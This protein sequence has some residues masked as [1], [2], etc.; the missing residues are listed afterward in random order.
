MPL[1]ARSLSARVL[2]RLISAEAEEPDPWLRDVLKIAR[3]TLASAARGEAV[4]CS[5]H[6]LASYAVLGLH[7]EKVWPAIQARR[8]ALGPLSE[9]P[10]K[11]PAQSVKLWFEKTNDARAVNS[12]AANSNDLRDQTISVPMAAPSINALYPNP[13]APSSGKRGEY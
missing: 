10:P 12:C 1:P 2:A 5:P 3:L 9:A 4:L 11:K 13:D 7:P 8:N 6:V